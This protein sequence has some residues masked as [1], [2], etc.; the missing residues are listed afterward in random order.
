MKPLYK[1][2]KEIGTAAVRFS[3][4]DHPVR[5][6]VEPE[7]KE[8]SYFDVLPLFWDE[9]CVECV[10]LHDGPNGLKA[11]DRHGIEY[12]ND[13]QHMTWEDIEVN[14]FDWKE[15]LHMKK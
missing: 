12:D 11:G 14:D 5:C 1:T 4:I 6:K 15:Y 2:M 3:K 7:N 8:A 9:E 10:M 13:F